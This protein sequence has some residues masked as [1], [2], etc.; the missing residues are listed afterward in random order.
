MFRRCAIAACLTLAAVT[1]GSGTQAGPAPVKPGGVVGPQ[2]GVQPPPTNRPD[3]RPQQ[4]GLL[5]PDPAVTEII[6]PRR[7]RPGDP[8]TFPPPSWVGVI[9]NI[10]GQ[11]YRGAPGRQRVVISDRISRVLSSSYETT[12]LTQEFTRLAPGESIRI[13]FETPSDPSH[14]ATKHLITVSIGIDPRN[15][16]D[17]DPLNN[18]CNAGN[19]TLTVTYGSLPSP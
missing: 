3:T 11:E 10:G 5:C 1:L 7:L 4:P 12:I 8:A 16:R 6:E 14:L 13:S 9:K 17:A 15:A 19:N 18:D 2:S